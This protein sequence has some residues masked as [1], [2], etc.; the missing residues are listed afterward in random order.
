MRTW[1]RCERNCWRAMCRW[2][3]ITTLR[4]MIPKERLICAAT[5]H[6]RVLHHALMNLCEP[7]LERA[8]VFDSYACRKGK[9]R[10]LAVE[11]AQGYARTHGWF[12]KM[13]IR[14]YFDSIDPRDAAGVV[15]A[16][17]QRP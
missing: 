4:C 9:G 14:K 13:D 8:A 2:E 1:R 10:L 11:R 5:F 12:L 16:E 15:G 17:V 7:V 3:T 6:E